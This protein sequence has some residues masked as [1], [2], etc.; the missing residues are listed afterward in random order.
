MTIPKIRFFQLEKQNLLAKN[1]A[2]DYH[3]LLR[4][5]IALHSTDYLTPYFSLWARQDEF[6]PESML[7]D[8]N[9]TRT[10]L[11]LRAFRGTV[12]VMDKDLIQ[13]TIE[14]KKYYYA[15]SRMGEVE[16]LSKKVG[17]DLAAFEKRIDRL[18]EGRRVLSMSEIKKE[19]AS[20]LDVAS[21]VFPYWLRYLEFIGMLCRGTQKHIADRSVKYALLRELFP[22]IR[23]SIAPEEA[24][25]SL[26]ERYIG[27]FGP[28]A[29]E[30]LCWWFPVTKTMAR[31]SL[32][33]MGEKIVSFSHDGRECFME[34]GDYELYKDY[35]PPAST[36]NPAVAFLP[37]E[38]H[39][40][41]AYFL[42][43][44]FL[45][46]E[47]A[48]IVMRKGTIYR[49]QIFPSIWV[50]GEIVGGWEIL[51]GDKRKSSAKI[52]ITGLVSQM[53]MKI[54]SHHLIESKRQELEEFINVSICPL[55]KPMRSD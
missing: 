38:D 34:A 48:K 6:K 36:K 40:P 23:T 39:F 19:L 5:H 2:G 45:S 43:D 30:D 51:W 44:W 42:R 24:F 17:F 33:R 9:I 21:E 7:E 25:D 32:G 15:A 22:Q 31:E 52:K 47:A 13:E 18:L 1:P 4:K 28:V 54:P 55:M 27:L 11:R 49:G 26:M 37:Y 35:K 50:N 29:L 46:P 10:A 20:E 8:L 14:A 16:K 12:F 53:G 41:K 3:P